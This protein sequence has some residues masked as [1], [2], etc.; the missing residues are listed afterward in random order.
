MSNTDE[1]FEIIER[2]NQLLG[3]FAEW[4]MKAGLNPLNYELIEEHRKDGIIVWYFQKRVVNCAE[5]D[6]GES[7]HLN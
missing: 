7:H 4:V 2:R 1:R 5:Q 3:S 6:S